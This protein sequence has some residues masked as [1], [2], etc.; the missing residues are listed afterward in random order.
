MKPTVA[1]Y[2]V[3]KANLAS[4]KCGW[5]LTSFSVL[6]TSLILSALIQIFQKGRLRNQ[7]AN[8]YK[9]MV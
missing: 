2:D 8:V 9:T 5:K 6:N 3:I 1:L 4:L 7:I